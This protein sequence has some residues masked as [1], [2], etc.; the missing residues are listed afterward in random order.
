MPSLEFMSQVDC[1]VPGS[2]FSHATGLAQVAAEATDL[3][4]SVAMDSTEPSRTTTVEAATSL[5]GLLAARSRARA[6]NALH[7]EPA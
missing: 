7:A 5:S 1:G 4:W 6:T 3:A 2:W